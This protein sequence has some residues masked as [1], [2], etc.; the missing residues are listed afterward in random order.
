M[1]PPSTIPSPLLSRYRLTVPI[2][3][4]SLP[5]PD[6]VK[7]RLVNVTALMPGL[8]NWNWSTGTL[9]VPGNWVESTGADVP[10]LMDTVTEVAV[11][12]AVNTGV[13]LGVGLGVKV[14]VFVEV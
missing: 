1:S 3:V 8:C 14:F 9:P 7:V 13:W 11:E 10:L 4:L 5:L 2:P 12:V 6:A